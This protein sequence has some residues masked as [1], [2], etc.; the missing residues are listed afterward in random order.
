MVV[1]HY[2]N[3]I[4]LRPHVQMDILR[5]LGS[6][7]KLR[8]SLDVVEIVLG[9]LTSGG[10]KPKIKLSSYL[11]TL[12]MEKKPFSEKVT[13]SMWSHHF[14]GLVPSNFICPLNR[15]KSTATWSTFC[16]CGRLCL[17]V[18]QDSS[19]SAVR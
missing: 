14:A 16:L 1:C 12:K 8:K 6:P 3:Q 19:P 13:Q 18:W 17:L 5:E 4:S 10:G 11:K 2:C 15:P 7:D 9:F